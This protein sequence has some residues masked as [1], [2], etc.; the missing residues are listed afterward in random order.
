[1]DAKPW[2]WSKTI[3]FNVLSFVVAVAVSLGYT[4]DIPAEWKEYVGPVVAVINVLLRL[5]T[6]KAI[7][8]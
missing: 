1:M 3:W 5:V 8:R 2:Y 6:S 4:G 7:N